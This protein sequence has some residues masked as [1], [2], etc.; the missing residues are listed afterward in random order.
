[1]SRRPPV[2]VAR[3]IIGV[4]HEPVLLAARGDAGSLYSL[5]LQRSGAG[6]LVRCSSISSG[7][8]SEGVPAK[9]V[10]WLAAMPAAGIVAV[11][12]QVVD[13]GAEHKLC[14]A[15]ASLV[16]MELKRERLTW[17]SNRRSFVGISIG[18]QKRSD[19][20]SCTALEIFC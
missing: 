19:L 12:V 16:V 11:Q 2:D 10:H 18:G 20:R 17:S 7:A 14:Q 6:F 5:T 4:G 13:R 15:R 8:V 9:D 1:M 3:A